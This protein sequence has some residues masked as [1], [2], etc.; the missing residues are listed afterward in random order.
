MTSNPPPDDTA[1]KLG[2]LRMFLTVFTLTQFVMVGVVVFSINK[3]NLALVPEPAAPYVVLGLAV[4]A[5]GLIAVSLRTV[6][7]AVRQ[8]KAGE[9]DVFARFTSEVLVRSFLVNVPGVILVMGYVLTAK[10]WLLVPAAVGLIAV[11]LTKPDRA[12]FDRWRADAG[13]PTPTA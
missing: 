5:V 4:L 3:M 12:A 6:V 1:K 13:Q 8:A 7:L 2:S 10:D 9:P 11:W